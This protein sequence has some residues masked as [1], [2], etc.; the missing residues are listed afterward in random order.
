MIEAAIAFAKDKNL[1]QAVE[2]C[3]KEIQNPQTKA[4]ALIGVA[5]VAEK[6]KQPEKAASLRQ[7]AVPLLQQ[8]LNSTQTIEDSDFK[9]N[10]LRAIAEAYIKLN[11]PDKASALSAILRSTSKT[12]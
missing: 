2:I 1:A 3:D 7:K 5:E 9:A 4:E 8:V 12:E 6:L 10:A 11:Q